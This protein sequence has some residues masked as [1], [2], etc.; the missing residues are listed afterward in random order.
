MFALSFA[1]SV[2]RSLGH[3]AFFA[4]HA[5]HGHLGLVLASRARESSLAFISLTRR[6]VAV[7]FTVTFRWT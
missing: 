5:T 1:R 3:F 7:T 2:P 4:G 6:S